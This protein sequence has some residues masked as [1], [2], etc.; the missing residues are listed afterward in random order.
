M[1]I[2][3]PVDERVR[4]NRQEKTTYS[5]CD[6]G[7]SPRRLR[8]AQERV[9]QRLLETYGGTG[10][11]LPVP[12]QRVTSFTLRGPRQDGPSARRGARHAHRRRLAGVQRRAR[13]GGTAAS[14]SGVAGAKMYA[15]ASSQGIPTS[16]PSSR[17]SARRRTSAIQAASISA[18]R[19]GV[20][21]GSPPWSM[22]A[23]SSVS[24]A[25]GRVAGARVRRS[26]MSMARRYH[27]GTGAA[28]G[29]VWRVGG[30]GD[31]RR[32]GIV[33]AVRASYLARVPKRPRMA[34]VFRRSAY[35]RP[36]MARASVGLAISRPAW[37]AHPT[38]ASMS[39]PLLRARSP[40]GK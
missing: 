40:F 4:V 27:D 15:R 37:R 2:P 18:S 19:S 10:I 22:S 25:T 3:D 36:S 32:H 11:V 20:G 33:L 16:R 12:E 14:S 23:R 6:L 21:F 38:I 9:N 39:S 13:R 26:S 5:W 31:L 1:W 34:R 24:S 29:G 35:A 28:T 8:E 7:P 30:R 17:S